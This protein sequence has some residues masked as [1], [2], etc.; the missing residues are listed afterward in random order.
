M[1]FEIIPPIPAASL[2]P[3]LSMPPVDLK[4][5]EKYV[6]KIVDKQL[7]NQEKS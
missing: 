6:Q 7:D 2:F 5:L 4:I 1:P 3:Q